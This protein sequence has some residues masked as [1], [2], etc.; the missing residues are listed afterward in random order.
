VW[1]CYHGQ[2]HTDRQ[3]R[4]TNTHLASATPHAKR[5]ESVAD[6]P[7][8]IIIPGA[9]L[10]VGTLRCVDIAARGRGRQRRSCGRHC[11]L[12]PCDSGSSIL[13]TGLLHG[14]IEVPSLLPSSRHVGRFSNERKPCGG[15][16]PIAAY[17]NVDNADFA[18]VR[19]AFV[20]STAKL[21][22]ARR[23]LRPT[24]CQSPE[25][26]ADMSAAE[27]LKLNLSPHCLSLTDVP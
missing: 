5:N 8:L 23:G 27:V 4:V 16:V 13:K 24:G 25:G 20:A 22:C 18:H 12:S 19:N 1:E 26:N 10:V 17:C 7:R 14:A 15:S 21:S 9:R 6:V 11:A 3:T 2:T